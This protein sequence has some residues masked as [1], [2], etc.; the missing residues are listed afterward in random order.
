MPTHLEFSL[1]GLSLAAPLGPSLRPPGGRPEAHTEP[2]EAAAHDDRARARL[3]Q[4]GRPGQPQEAGGTE[5]LSSCVD[6]G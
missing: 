2:G 3:P 5:V 4:A 1:V 6:Q